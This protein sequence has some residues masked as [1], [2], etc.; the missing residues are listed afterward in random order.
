MKKGKKVYLYI[1][2]ALFAT[3]F[4][5]LTQRLILSINKTNLIFFLAILSG[6]LVGLIIKFFL[7]K[8]YI[9]FDKKKDFLY[10]GEKF[11]LYTIMG[12]FSTVV[13]W[14]TESI[15]W[16]IWR[17]EIMR[18]LGAILGLTIGYIL[19]YRLDKRYVFNKE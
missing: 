6:T 19:K 17:K 5:L 10:L 15:F 12:I 8:S 9:F 7:D 2:F 11:R 1:L 16:I 14:G 3:F 4:N 13:F 18:E